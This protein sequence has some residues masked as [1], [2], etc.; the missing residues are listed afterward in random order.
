MSPAASSGVQQVAV[1][2]DGSGQRLDRWFKQHYP[3]VTHGRLEKMLRK[4]EIRVDGK[5]VKASQ[6]LEEGQVVR[7][8]PLPPVEAGGA[9]T[10]APLPAV[11]ATARPAAGGRRVGEGRRGA[12]GGGALSRR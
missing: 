12:A 10:P 3:Q 7:V 5:R 9:E 2:A 6:R 1:A 11:S 8:P 4:G